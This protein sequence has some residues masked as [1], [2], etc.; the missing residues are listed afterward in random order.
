MRRLLAPVSVVMT[1]FV[2]GSFAA[3]FF[4]AGA[5]SAQWDPVAT[6]DP[7]PGC[8]WM[9]CV[10]GLTCMKSLPLSGGQGKALAI[11]RNG[12]ADWGAYSPLAAQSF[13]NLGP[14]YFVD[15]LRGWAVSADDL[16]ANAGTIAYTRDGGKTF[17]LPD[18]LTTLSG[19][20]PAVVANAT[21]GFFALTML[22]A[23]YGWAGGALLDGGAQRPFLLW[24]RNGGV[25]WREITSGDIS[26]FADA[27]IQ[28]IHFV[29]MSVGYVALAGSGL[30]SGLFR[31]QDSGKS[32]AEVSF[33][34]T[35]TPDA[36]NNPVLQIAFPSKDVGYALTRQAS[37]T[38]T[39]GLYV[40]TD[41]GNTWT[42]QPI[43]AFSGDTQIDM[44]AWQ[45]AFSDET[46][47][48]VVGGDSGSSPVI[49]ATSDGGQRWSVVALPSGW[50][51][52]SSPIECSAAASGGFQYAAGSGDNRLLRHLATGTG[53]G[54]G[55]DG[56]MP[57]NGSS[58]ST[59]GDPGGSIP[60]DNPPA[61]AK[62]DD[63]CS[64][65][66]TGGATPGWLG[67]LLLG[68]LTLRRRRFFVGG[69]RLRS[70]SAP[71]FLRKA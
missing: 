14:F 12:G 45:M 4:V 61:A 34:A 51:T 60:S 23:N 15:G 69:P 35:F 53:G 41:G 44:R 70:P 29:D 42:P 55:G 17:M 65:G 27:R 66:Q 24:T 6:V 64:L 71:R 59:G 39:G 19:A 1:L 40:T 63:G 48:F 18:S 54:G 2:A 68:A 5:A 25:D 46:H 8:R 67:V 13:Y 22:D 7:F 62:D 57:D 38:L 32:F 56:G 43:M 9:Q 31:T 52:S 37:D 33:G 11:T 21:T 49:L 26:G 58:G 10:D 16:G 36:R 30:I 3:G 47:G 20:I 28:A 50:G